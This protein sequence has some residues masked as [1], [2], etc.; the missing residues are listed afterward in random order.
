MYTKNTEC[1]VSKMEES[2][3]VMKKDDN[4]LH[5]LNE[6]ASLIWEHIE[7]SS[8]DDIVKAI[9]SKYIDVPDDVVLQDVSNTINSFVQKGLLT[10]C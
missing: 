7:D 9:V 2:I 1:D 6:T 3:I 5:I 10:P 4:S 8:I